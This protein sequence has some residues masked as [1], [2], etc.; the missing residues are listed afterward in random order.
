MYDCIIVGAGP[1]GSTAAKTLAEKGFKLLLVEKFKLPRYKSC[2]GILIKKT[3]DLV[4]R[5]FGEDTPQLALCAP[6][7]N[8]GMIFT[9]DKGIE[10]RFEQ[11][12][13]NVWRSFFDNWLTEKASERGAEVRECTTVI[14]CEEKADYV[15]VTLYD[16]KTYTVDAR[17]V[18]DCE[19]VVGSLQ[20]KLCAE[21][22]EYVTTFQSFKCSA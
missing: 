3:M 22:Q 19:G 2:S 14:G 7:E 10:H 20:R 11:E 4:R 15:A 6:H 12:G 16:A 1:A 9:T 17:C 21:S 8:R 13:L 18:L 5:Y